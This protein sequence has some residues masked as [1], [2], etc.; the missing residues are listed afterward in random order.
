[1][2]KKGSTILLILIFVVGLGIFAYPKVA[3]KWNSYHSS[4]AIMAYN[5][6]VSGMSDEEYERLISAAEEY[7]R[8]VLTRS[9]PYTPTDEELAEYYTLLDVAG[10]GVMGYIEIPFINVSLPVYHGTSESVLQIA[11]GHL[12][13]T[14]LPVGGASTHAVLSGH[15]GLPSAELF[16]H[17]DR[18]VEGDRFMLYI[19]NDVLTYE[20]D[21]IH[22][23]LP[24]EISDL[25]ITA[26][27]DY[28]TLITCTPYGV[29]THRMLVRGHR[30]DTEFE[31][32]VRVTSD[33]IQI[34]PV[35][36]A[37]IIGIPFLIAV[38]TVMFISDR[39][40]W[41]EKLENEDQ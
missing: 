34:E 37:P 2:R 38:L 26:G 36:V 9:N 5:D 22:I 23:V 25:Q 15:R 29:N 3:D 13:W 32:N 30:V 35:L 19:L 8:N 21:Q 31:H 12:E 16:T 40:Q 28:C 39:K 4:R 27:E 1:M 11:V 20:I 17:L 7:N 33:A 14:S 24:E 6:V 41:N 18:L 10:N